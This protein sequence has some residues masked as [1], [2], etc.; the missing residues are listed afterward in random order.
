MCFN[1]SLSAMDKREWQTEMFHLFPQ[2]INQ[3]PL[4]CTEY[5]HS[6][7]IGERAAH[8][9]L[10]APHTDLSVST[11]AARR[12]SARRYLLDTLCTSAWSVHLALAAN[13]CTH[14]WTPPQRQAACA[15]ALT[16]GIR[17]FAL[18]PSAFP[19][20]SPSS[21][22]GSGLRFLLRPWSSAQ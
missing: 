10:F 19:N 22:A 14:L 18:A 11:V 21:L 17:I 3:A 7:L 15:T 5:S 2:W 13:P 6:G 8:A 4:P 16:D 9:R 20:R 12:R 1:T